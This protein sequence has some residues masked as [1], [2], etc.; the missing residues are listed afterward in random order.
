MLQR[1]TTPL[2]QTRYALTDQQRNIN[3]VSMIP[4][5]ASHLLP[6]GIHIAG[7]DEL[8]ERFGF[9]QRRLWLLDGLRPA[10]IEL[11]RVGCEQ[12]YLD[13]SFVTSK[14]TPGDYDLCWELTN[15]R[16]R[17]LDPVFFDLAAP[18]AR[19]RAKYR[20]DLLPNI[21]EGSSGM[22][23]VDFFQVEKDSGE[24][25]GILVIDPRRIA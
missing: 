5:F 12:V 14:A 10:L 15:V 22:P 13:G 23:F 20:G 8:V 6:P 3:V 11:A 7:W 21:V 24:T 16:L 18:R 9:S 17:E 2:Q 25:K 4:A 1:I 19:Q